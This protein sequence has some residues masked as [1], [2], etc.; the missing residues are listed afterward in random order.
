MGTFEQ[1]AAA[2]QR[3][4]DIEPLARFARYQLD[5]GNGAMADADVPSSPSAALLE[6]LPCL[7]LLPLEMPG[8]G[9]EAT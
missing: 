6:V 4:D 1:Q 3:L 9:Y 5:Q 7:S 2:Q 8:E